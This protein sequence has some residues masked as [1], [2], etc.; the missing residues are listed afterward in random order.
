MVTDCNRKGRPWQRADQEN[1]REE[2]K[3]R[4]LRQ[5]L[6]LVKETPTSRQRPSGVYLLGLLTTVEQ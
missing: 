5:L 6:S 1:L 4:C 2:D 3:G